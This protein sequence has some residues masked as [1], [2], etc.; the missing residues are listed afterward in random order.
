MKN[1]LNL[2]LFFHLFVLCNSENKIPIH[3]SYS[4]NQ[5]KSLLSKF[6]ELLN[7]EI[8]L[9]QNTLQSSFFGFPD[10]KNFFEIINHLHL[11]FKYYLFKSRDTRKICLAGL[12]KNII[13][14][15]NIEKQICF[16][17]SKKN[18]SKKETK[19]KKTKFTA[20]GTWAGGGKVNISILLVF[21][22]KSFMHCCV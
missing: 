8:L 17:G 6:Q 12:K 13:K 4:R 20:K 2:K 9:P 14:T 10:N 19:L 5:V 22:L 3:L 11:V 16:N 7:S 1:F 21:A 18:K 15:C